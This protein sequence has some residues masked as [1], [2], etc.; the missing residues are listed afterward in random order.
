MTKLSFIKTIRQVNSLEKVL[1]MIMVFITRETRDKVEIQWSKK[2]VVHNIF[3]MYEFIFWRKTGIRRESLTYLEGRKEVH[4]AFTFEAK[5]SLIESYLRNLLN[6]I[7]KLKL[8]KIYLPILIPNLGSFA[9]VKPYVLAIAL[10]SA[11]NGVATSTSPLTF[12]H[13]S[14]GT[15]LIL[16]VAGAVF[17]ATTSNLTVAPTYNSV[18]M[19]AVIGTSDWGAGGGCALRPWYQTNPSTG[20]NTISMPFTGTAPTGNAAAVSYSGARQSSQPDSTASNFSLSISLTT[21]ANN[22]WAIGWC[23]DVDAITAN[24]TSRYTALLSTNT[25]SYEDSNGP[26]TPAGAFTISYTGTSLTP[27]LIAYSFAPFSPTSN[28]SILGAG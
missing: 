1:P 10:D 26:V 28:L 15:N 9:V 13:T 27:A 21:H 7:P 8:E 18:S 12:S 17:S 24:L 16:T 2:S 23:G 4:V 19:T 14:T 3:R 5:C 6:K 22:S 20:S 11:N 25:V